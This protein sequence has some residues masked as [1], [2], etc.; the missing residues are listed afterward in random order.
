MNDF[1]LLLSPAEID[2]LGDFLASPTLA[3]KAMTVPAL[4]GYLTAIVIGP[5]VVLPSLWLPW[6]WD[7]DDGEADPTFADLDQANRI[8]YLLMRFMN[9]IISAFLDNSA[10]FEPIYWRAM[11]RGGAVE[12]GEGFMLGTQFNRSDWG[13]LWASKPEWATPFVRLGT[14]EG[15]EISRRMDDIER[16]MEA[17]A[18]TVKD[19]RAFWNV[20]RVGTPGVSKDECHFGRQRAP[21]AREVPKTGRNDPCPCG[22]G[23]KFKKC[24]GASLH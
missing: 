1:N 16:W 11:H 9:G 8:M 3:E 5:Q 15:R 23:K 19:I 7:M 21:A 6:V 24:C 4:E 2:E 12:W 20:R 22:S 18:P 17:V 10:P 13:R 14:D